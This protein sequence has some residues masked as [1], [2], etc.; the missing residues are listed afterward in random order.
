MYNTLRRGLFL[1]IIASATA[2]IPLRTKLNCWNSFSRRFYTYMLIQTCSL[3]EPQEFYHPWL[4]RPP[5][6]PSRR[7]KF[8]VALH[9]LFLSFSL[10]FALSPV[11][12]TSTEY[13][14]RDIH[15]STE[16]SDNRL[17]KYRFTTRRRYP[18]LSFDSIFAFRVPRMGAHTN[19]PRV[20]ASVHTVDFRKMN[21]SFRTDLHL[22]R[23][24]IELGIEI[25][26]IVR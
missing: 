16:S 1:V 15:R 20:R 2:K 19:V 24:K 10:S 14:S 12:C 17:K 6:S 11:S 5:C 4:S 25:R 3:T 18:F 7:Y 13:A 22:R 9:S 26:C 23:A 8:R 21:T